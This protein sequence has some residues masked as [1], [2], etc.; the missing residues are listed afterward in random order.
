MLTLLAQFSGGIEPV[1]RADFAFTDPTAES[2]GATTE[3]IISQTI[4]AIT[5]VAVVVFII[6]FIYGALQWILAGGDA[7]KISQARQRMIQGVIGLALV[8]LAYAIIGL[9]GTII[10]IDL[11]NVGA[12]IEGLDPSSI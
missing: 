12:L 6:F 3:N 1:G 10:G 11:L 4:G 2:V 9:I 7:S 8:V 5:I